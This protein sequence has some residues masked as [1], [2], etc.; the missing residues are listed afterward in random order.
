[1]R[2]A[3]CTYSTIISHILLFNCDNVCTNVPQCYVIRTLPA[4]FYN[5]FYSLTS[6]LPSLFAA[7]CFP[8]SHNLRNMCSHFV[9]A[10][11]T[12]LV[13]ISATLLGY[14]SCSIHE[15]C[16]SNLSIVF[17]RFPFTDKATFIYFRNVLFVTLFSCITSRNLI[18][19]QN[20]LFLFYLHANEYV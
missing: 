17:F 13:I 15:V 4:L 10:S 12:F 9:S 7:I 2:I 8:I 5:W 20:E 16:A 3:C 14:L 6:L 1:M 11:F 18:K 19:N